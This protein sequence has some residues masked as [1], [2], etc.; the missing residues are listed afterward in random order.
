MLKNGTGLSSFNFQH[1]LLFQYIRGNA[2]HSPQWHFQ[3]K[4][5]EYKNISVLDYHSQSSVY[6]ICFKKR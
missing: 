2:Y 1:I 4:F 5:I 3:D 6:L